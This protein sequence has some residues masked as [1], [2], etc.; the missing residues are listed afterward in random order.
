MTIR[1]EIL[2]GP[3]A[4]RARLLA[5]KTPKHADSGA[6][7]D[8]VIP[9]EETRRTDTRRQDRR[10]SEQR[11]VQLMFRDRVHDA[12]LLNVSGGGA[13]IGAKLSPII[14]EAVDLHMPGGETIE[15]AVRWVKDDR[16]GL[17]FA[18]GTK[19]DCSDDKRKVVVRQVGS[20]SADA[21]EMLPVTP[22]P[23]DQRAAERHPLIWSGELRHGT[24]RC[25]VRLRN[26]SAT[27]A[28][29]QSSRRL[30]TDVEVFLDLGD[31]W[32]ITATISWVAGDLAGLQF[33]E[34]F[35]VE[36][37]A[38]CKPRATSPG[39][40]RPAYL[41]DDSTAQSAWDSPWSQMTPTELRAQLDDLIKG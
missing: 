29:V 8:I 24:H 36:Q 9:R 35:D 20:R 39:W 40:L 3:E 31:G 28:L 18:H 32:E 19:L 27:G 38:S 10:S 22:D 25:P 15:C 23:R 12:E 7:T 34:P 1:A 11:H 13:M 16:L 6:L 17:E 5:R 21:I 26:I 14:G 41:D 30:R 2:G 37:L 4:R 33:A